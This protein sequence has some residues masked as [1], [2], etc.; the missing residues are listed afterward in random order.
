VNR[1]L[2]IAQPPAKPLM[3]YDGDCHFCKFAVKKWRHISDPQV[4]YIASQDASVTA[5][6]PEIPRDLFDRSVALLEPD[7]FVYEGAEAA[8]RAL[9]HGRMR[10]PLWIY[11]HL[12]L[13]AP[14]AEWG[15]RRVARN[16]SIF[17]RLLRLSE[18]S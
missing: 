5:R 15:Y 17:S 3:I 7:G 18:K 13:A 12:P 8:L 6:F 2:H 4:D 14:L 9:A 11:R 16:R 1:V 10:W